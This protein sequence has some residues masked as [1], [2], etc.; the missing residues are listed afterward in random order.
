MSNLAAK[1]QW[2]G[3]VQM[4]GGNLDF[5]SRYN[6]APTPNGIWSLSQGTGLSQGQ[7]GYEAPFTIVA[8]GSL[9]IDLAG[10]GGEVN[11]INQLLTAFPFTQV[12][13]VEIIV[14]TPQSAA[15]AINCVDTLDFVDSTGSGTFTVEIE[16]I[17][18]GAITYS[19]TPAT[20]VTHINTALNAAFGT[21][22]IVC[23]GASLAALILTYT[24]T[25]YAGRPIRGLPTM[26]VSGGTGF[27]TTPSRTTY[28]GAFVVFGPQGGTDSAQLWFGGVTT[29]FGDTIFDRY[30]VQERNYGWGLYSPNSKL[31]LK[32]PSGVSVS[33]WIRVLGV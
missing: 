20:L 2:G 23:S 32:N 16:G 28:G 9:T 31:L 19:A 15:A 25:P 17:T 33:G 7:N 10:S 22:V 30:S 11:M 3:N 4:S 12:K 26:N 18:T 6:T 21:G 5:V 24:L 1:I 8:A 29:L 27:T 14:T 13:S